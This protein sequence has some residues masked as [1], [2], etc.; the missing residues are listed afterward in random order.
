MEKYRDIKWYKEMEIV[1]EK[2]K[3]REKERHKPVQKTAALEKIYY[4]PYKP[5]GE[6][7]PLK[8]V[9]YI[10]VSILVIITAYTLLDI[11]KGEYLYSRTKEEFRKADAT[12]HKNWNQP[13]L[14]KELPKTRQ[15]HAKK[16]EIR[17]QESIFHQDI[18]KSH[19]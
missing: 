7:T 11:L 8:L 14:N 13:S 6:F 1:R 16:K 4:Q 5:Q 19:Q 2:N 10:T 17:Q 9:I 18:R 12:L 3:E 15:E